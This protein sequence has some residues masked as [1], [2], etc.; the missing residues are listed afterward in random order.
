MKFNLYFD[1]T[2]YHDMPPEEKSAEELVRLVMMTADG[3]NIVIRKY[4][5][6]EVHRC[7]RKLIEKGIVRGTIFDSDKC[8]W[9]RLTPKGILY[10]KQ[11]MS[12]VSLDSLLNFF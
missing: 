3:Q 10:F 11:V 6:Q 4:S 9:S 2:F 8:S 7:I 1:E 12:E 5:E